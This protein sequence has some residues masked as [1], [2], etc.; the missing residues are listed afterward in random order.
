MNWFVKASQ[1][2]VLSFHSQ[3]C[4]KNWSTWWFKFQERLDLTQT[5][6]TIEIHGSCRPLGCM[7]LCVLPGYPSIMLFFRF[8]DRQRKPGPWLNWRSQRALMQTPAGSEATELESTPAYGSSMLSM[9]KR[10]KT[11]F[12]VPSSFGVRH[13]WKCPSF[14]SLCSMAPNDLNSS[15]ESAST[16]PE[17]SSSQEWRE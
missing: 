13:S 11:L 16:R 3:N 1:Y 15:E 7:C 6:L 8:W 12:C 9:G 14:P 17:A 2:N 5:W 10:A 4:G